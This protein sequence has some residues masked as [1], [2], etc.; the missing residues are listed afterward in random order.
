MYSK[1]YTNRGPLASSRSSSRRINV[2]GGGD[3][4]LGEKANPTF[5]GAVAGVGPMGE[6]GGLGAGGGG[7]SGGLGIRFGGGL[8]GG[9]GGSGGSGD[10]YRS[11][12]TFST[13]SPAAI[14][15]VWL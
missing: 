4:G 7:A 6:G 12:K 3:G 8:G 10:R 1:H 15:R 5:A 14:A 2:G 9:L 13:G 11:G